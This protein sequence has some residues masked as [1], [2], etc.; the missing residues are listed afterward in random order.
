MSDSPP[1]FTETVLLSGDAQGRQIV[2]IHAKRTYRLR[3]R[4]RGGPLLRASRSA[5]A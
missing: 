5:G 2:S 3:N 4:S 1:P